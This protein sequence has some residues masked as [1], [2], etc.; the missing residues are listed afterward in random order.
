MDNNCWIPENPGLYLT[1]RLVFGWNPLASGRVYPGR[2]P[3]CPAF[4]ELTRFAVLVF[5]ALYLFNRPDF[6][7]LLIRHAAAAAG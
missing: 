3:G 4:V 7:A 6:G 5:A 2:L 1:S